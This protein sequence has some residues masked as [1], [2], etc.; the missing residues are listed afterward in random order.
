MANA[1]IHESPA[2]EVGGKII[3]KRLLQWVEEVAALCKPD[4]V[5][6][7]DGSDQEYQL[8]LRVMLH[9]GTAI[10]L[11]PQKRPNSI[12]VRS[13]TLDVA[14]VEDKTF[15]CSA[16]A[17]EAGPNNNWEE[18]VRMKRRLNDLFSGSMRGR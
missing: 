17:D 11:N 10:S 4:S 16:T 13:T 12:F 18:P 2:S 5:R 8:M 7:C 6:L 1:Q 9:S 14:R 3:N 15:V